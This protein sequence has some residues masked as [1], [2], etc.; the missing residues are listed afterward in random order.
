MPPAAWAGVSPAGIVTRGTAGRSSVAP[1]GGGEKGPARGLFGTRPVLQ[2]TRRAGPGG[3]PGSFPGAQVLNT[4]TILG[5]AVGLAMDAFAVSIAAGLAVRN[6]SPRHM[7]RLA[8]H[9]GLFQFM[10]PVIGWWA[11]RRISDW[12]AAFD[13]WLAFGLL[14]FIGGRMLYEAVHGEERGQRADPTRGWLLVSLSVATSIDALAVGFSLALLGDGIWLA[15]A[16]IG[17]VACGFTAIGITF[18]ARLLAGWARAADALGG[19]VLILIGVRIVL[20]H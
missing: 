16:V 18:G 15:A 9:F 13:H 3:A 12:V 4:L 8:W 6:V 20:T 7:F 11:G 2:C 5:I 19:C 17:L 14:A 10:M 1:A